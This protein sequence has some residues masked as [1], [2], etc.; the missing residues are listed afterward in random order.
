MRN[1]EVL[2]FFLLTPSHQIL[3]VLFMMQILKL[4]CFLKTVSYLVLGNLGMGMLI[5]PLLS[6]KNFVLLIH[7]LKIL[8]FLK[9]LRLIMIWVPQMNQGGAIV[10]WFWW[11]LL[12]RGEGGS[13]GWLGGGHGCNKDY[14]KGK[15]CGIKLFNIGL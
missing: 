8:F 10:G 5:N 15:I 13:L 3:L 14:K 12:F 6:F 9:N 11:E 1:L 4:F 2:L 7:K